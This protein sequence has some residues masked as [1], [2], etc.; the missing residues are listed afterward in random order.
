LIKAPIDAVVAGVRVVTGD[1]PARATPVAS[2]VEGNA[3]SIIDA[4]LGR[5][6]VEEA[7][8]GSDPDIVHRFGSLARIF[9]P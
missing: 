3:A 4:L 9:N 6:S 5:G 8:A 1:A 2:G 7:L